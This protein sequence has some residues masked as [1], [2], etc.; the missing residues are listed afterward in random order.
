MKNMALPNEYQYSTFNTLLKR[1]RLIIQHYKSILRGLKVKNCYFPTGINGAGDVCIEVK[2]TNNSGL[3][4]WVFGSRI[5]IYKKAFAIIASQNK[6]LRFYYN[7]KY[8]DY[9]Y[10][11]GVTYTVKMDKGVFYVNGNIIGSVN[12][13]SF[14]NGLQIYLCGLNPGGGNG[15]IDF[16]YAK[17]WKND[18]LVRDYIPSKVGG[19]Y[20]L[21]DKISGSFGTFGGDGTVSPIL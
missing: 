19:L 6:N 10:S 3:T 15:F 11:I 20:G 18:V 2:F 16:Y 21:Y 1:R 14:D 5:G 4:G 7:D 9:K 8:A 13:A 12:Q 17:I